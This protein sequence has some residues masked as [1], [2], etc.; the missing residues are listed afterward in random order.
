[1]GGLTLV[2]ALTCRRIE[3]GPAV[4]RLADD[5]RGG[6]TRG[7]FRQVWEPALVGALGTIRRHRSARMTPSSASSARIVSS[8]RVRQRLWDNRHAAAWLRR[9]PLPEQAAD[10][11]RRR[12]WRYWRG[13]AG[14]A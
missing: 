2:L 12:R 4:A 3:V 6:G 13:R 1:M 5:R 8:R 14:I 7:E 9:V 10:I 11:H